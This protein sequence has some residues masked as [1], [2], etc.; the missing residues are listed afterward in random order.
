MLIRV[1]SIASI[2]DVYE[3][4]KREQKASSTST[5]IWSIL[6]LTAMWV[7]WSTEGFPQTQWTRYQGNPVLDRGPEGSWDSEAVGM[8]SVLFDG[9][10]YHMWYAGNDG[11]NF[12][13]G[14]ATSE[15]GIS[16]EKDPLNPVLETGESG[17]WDDT[18]VFPAAGSVV[19]D[20]AIYHLWFGGV[21]VNGAYA[22]GHATSLDGIIWTKD[23][24]NPVMDPGAS[25]AWDSGGVVPG[26][27]LFDG[28]TYHAWYSGHSG[29]FR[30]RV[31]YATSP[32]GVEWTR[33]TPA[34]PVLDFGEIGN[35]D[36]EQAWNAS[37]HWD[38]VASTY[39]MWYNG[40]P[41]E[42]D[43][44]GYATSEV[45]DV[46][47]EILPDIPK[48]FELLQNYPNPFTTSTTI[49]FNIS[50]PSH[51]SLKIYNMLGHE[52]KVL[53]DGYRQEGNHSVLWEGTNAD[54]LPVG[55]GMYFY[56][57]TASD[58]TKA[59]KTLLLR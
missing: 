45:V 50:E 52:V 40:G 37:V 18:Q 29:N 59:G 35:W 51:V 49:S 17:S 46:A 25:N 1:T 28:T 10:I 24:S 38:S 11:S 4:D 30:Y 41:F 23:V 3:Q 36:A 44:M 54:G 31:G 19:F 32:D 16:W 20:G 12:S 39:K 5:R 47:N 21:K 2:A 57:M 14:H 8:G 9:S 33:E 27:V 48:R 6:I 56:R 43:Q 34:Q 58:Q 22:I 53:M 15:D 26:T 55:S 7:T 13:I 42:A